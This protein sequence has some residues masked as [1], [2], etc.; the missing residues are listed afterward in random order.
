M[1]K[2]AADVMA[3]ANSISAAIGYS[4]QPHER[5]SKARQ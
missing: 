4:E 1:E 5:D 3:A 2:I